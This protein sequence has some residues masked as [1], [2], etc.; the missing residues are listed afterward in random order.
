MSEKTETNQDETFETL[1]IVE[2]SD[3]QLD[4][5]AGGYLGEGDVARCWECKALFHTEQEAWNHYLETKHDRFSTW[6]KYRYLEDEYGNL[7]YG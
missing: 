2:L 6:P 7:S 1:E 5:I 4:A 3:E